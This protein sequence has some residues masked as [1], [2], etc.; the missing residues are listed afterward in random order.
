MAMASVAMAVIVIAVACQGYGSG[1]CG[2]WLLCCLYYFIVLYVK[3]EPLML[4][5][6]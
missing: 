1:G 4:N 6:L 3:I 5:V 2:Y